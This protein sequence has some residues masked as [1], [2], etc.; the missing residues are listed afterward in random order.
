MKE[1]HTKLTSIREKE[2]QT[3]CEVFKLKTQ[4]DCEG[5]TEKNVN[6][7]ETKYQVTVEKC[8]LQRHSMIN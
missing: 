8:K 3:R 6:K 5:E 7:R 4:K 1:K 2:K